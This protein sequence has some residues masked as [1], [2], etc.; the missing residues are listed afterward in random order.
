[1]VE[2]SLN[3]QLK[4]IDKNLKRMTPDIWYDTFPDK[5]HEPVHG[6]VY[7]AKLVNVALTKDEVESLIS[8][9]KRVI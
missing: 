4:E 9:K 7:G 6:L 2:K 8:S 5:D 3:Q 1:M